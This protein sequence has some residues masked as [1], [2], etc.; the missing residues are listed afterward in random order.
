MFRES[1]NQW[2]TNINNRETILLPDAITV[3]YSLFGLA[4]QTVGKFSFQTG[5]RFDARK[6]EFDEAGITSQ[7]YYR[8]CANRKFDNV[9]GSLGATYRGNE[10]LIFRV[11]GA[12]A[13][14]NPN[15]AELTSNGPHEAR[16][17]VGDVALKPKN[18]LSTI[19]VPITISITY[20]LMLQVFSIP[21]PI[22][23]TLH[24]SDCLIVACLN[25][26]IHRMMLT[27][28][29]ENLYCIFIP[30]RFSG[31]ILRQT[32]PWFL[33]K[34]RIVSTYPIFRQVNLLLKPVSWEIN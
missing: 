21:L 28:M 8:L 13:Y 16:Y 3:G 33:V 25:S 1:I 24:Q 26:D 20:L 23:F 32:I 22:T 31:F 27:Y 14:R 2:N 19:L 12:A 9:T 30:N 4:Q 11:N 34:N 7:P 18:R 6:L 15:L 17:E 29:V 5:L 10:N